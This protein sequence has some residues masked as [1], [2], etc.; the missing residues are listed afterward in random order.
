MKNPEITCRPIIKSDEPEIILAYDEIFKANKGLDY[1]H[2]FYG[3][4]AKGGLNGLVLT[5]DNLVIGAVLL[6]PLSCSYFDQEIK[7]QGIANEFIKPAF[8][9]KGYALVLNQATADFVNKTSGGFGFVSQRYQGPG[10]L[11]K[12]NTYLKTIG[13]LSKILKPKNE[14]DFE[15]LRS[16][17]GL[18]DDIL[19][20]LKEPLKP[21]KII[22][23][24]NYLQWRYLDAPGDSYRAHLIKKNSKIIGYLVLEI[25][26]K[27]IYVADL[28][29]QAND[30]L[31][32]ILTALT[33]WCQKE[34]YNQIKFTLINDLLEPKL[35]EN[36]YQLIN[37]DH[38]L[39]VT[40]K[41]LFPR[42]YWHIIYGDLL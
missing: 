32:E 27:I 24:K 8:R 15:P 11:L 36:G 31:A 38:W 16:F 30:C 29:Y 33:S 21:I 14:I 39:I 37:T 5:K 13:L 19:A 1:F 25:T 6:L 42:N 26:N 20:D 23:N 28:A 10:Q 18:A 12:V 22:K 9:Q 40:T 2:Y 17:N 41:N 34:N 3:S 4:S 7:L 35:I